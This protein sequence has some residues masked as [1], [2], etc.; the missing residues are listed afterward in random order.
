MYAGSPRKLEISFKK[1]VTGQFEKEASRKDL[2]KNIREVDIR[3]Q[4]KQ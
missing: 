4:M 1:Q 2:G 3:S